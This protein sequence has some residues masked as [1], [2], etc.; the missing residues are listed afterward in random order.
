LQ[1]FVLYCR[2]G[3]TFAATIKAPEVE[4]PDNIATDADKLTEI[5]FAEEVKEFVN[6]TRT[7]KSTVATIFAVAWGQCSDAMKARV[8]MHKGYEAM[9][10]ANHCV[11]ILGQICSVTLQFHDSKDSF[12][13]LLDAQFGFSSCKQKADESAD[14]YADTL[15]GWSDTIETHG[16]TVAV[17]FKLI[18]ATRSGTKRQAM[19]REHTIATALIR[20]A[21]PSR[22]GTL[23]TD[24]ANQ[25]AMHK[26]NYPTDMNSAK[27]LLVMYKTLANVLPRNTNNQQRR[28]KWPHAGAAHC[29][30]SRRHQRITP[31]QR[32][33]LRM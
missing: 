21:D 9:S 24:L 33:V 4:Q 3:A 16:G 19:A 11:W 5:I 14:D 27:S 30:C 32:H 25:Y 26:D 6:R 8:K 29:R 17:N 28:T 10:V 1:D 15:I 12:M 2:L 7:L 18:S 22:Y 20:N 31:S 23:I 13:S